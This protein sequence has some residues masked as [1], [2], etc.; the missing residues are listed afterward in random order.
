MI[1]LGF[2]MVC[3]VVCG[4][5]WW[6]IV[7][8]GEKAFEQPYDK[9]NKIANSVDPD[10]LRSSLVRVYTVRHLDALLIGKATHYS[11]LE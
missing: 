10:Q 3:G 9:T 1:C 2:G 5:L 4:V 7:F 11:I 6:C 8:S